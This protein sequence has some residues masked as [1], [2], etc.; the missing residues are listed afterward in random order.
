MSPMM[1]RA[2]RR[3]PFLIAPALLAFALGHAQAQKAPATL[4]LEEAIRLAA[5]YNPDFRVQANDQNVADWNVAEAYANLLPDFSVRSSLSYDAPGI[6]NVGGLQ[7]A[8]LGISRTPA[9]YRSSYGIGG[10]VFLSGATFFNIAQAKANRS[11]TDASVVAAE[12]TLAADVTR[13]YLTAMRSRDAVTVAKQS[14]AAASESKKLADARVQAGA[15][16]PLDAA[17]AD[18]AAGRAEVVLIQAEN[19]YENDKLRLL[20]R[21]GVTLD[22]A[23]ELTSTFDIFQP[24]WSL[25]ELTKIAMSNHPQL[26]SV[27]ATESARV[28]ASRASKMSYLP[29]LSLQGGW[30]GSAREV[31]DRNAVI[32]SAKS[33]IEGQ[34]RSC[35]QNNR[36]ATA[37]PGVLEGYPKDCSTFVYT[38]DIERAALEANNN[39]FPFRYISQ[40]PSFSATLS[41]PIFDG[42]SRER[43]M[44]TA[45]AE[46]DDAHQRRR[47]AE[48][49]QQTQ[50]AT[51]QRNVVAAHRSVEI[52]Q[53]NV[54]AAET[55]LQLAQERYRLGAGTFLDLM[56]AQTAKAQADRDYLNAVYGFHE[57]VAALESAVGQKL[58]K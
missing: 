44:Q 1:K 36:F 6:P 57:N 31:G 12:F 41:F 35:E 18:V 58:R 28:A 20:Q 8:E 50:V 55:A 17:Q 42:F 48:L 24:T 33:S 47:A 21:L 51:T 2:L 38:Q 13:D 11:A 7:G 45:R 40:P 19:T 53:R 37:V 9:V 23:V 54:K 5:R 15:A 10:G 32:A 43:Q 25:E 22:N 3:L 52:E 14:L 26:R 29:S 46:A 27:R 30:G 56:Q 34:R 49:Q 39:I 4:T 16:T